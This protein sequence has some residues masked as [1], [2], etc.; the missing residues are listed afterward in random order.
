M[1]GSPP[2]LWWIITKPFLPCWRIARSSGTIIPRDVWSPTLQLPFVPTLS[3]TRGD[4]LGALTPKTIPFHMGRGTSKN[5]LV[6]KLLLAILLASI[7]IVMNALKEMMRTMK[8]KKNK[9]RDKTKANETS[10]YWSR[11]MHIKWLRWRLGT[12]V[13]WENNLRLNGMACDK[14]RKLVVCEASFNMLIWWIFVWHL[15]II[16][17]VCCCSDEP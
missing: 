5:A 10:I 4:V 15:H 11:G 2:S 16:A 12:N 17:T 8:E 6:F 14:T 7:E 13:T 9:T 1:C 3:A